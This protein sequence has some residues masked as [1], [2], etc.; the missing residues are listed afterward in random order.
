MVSKQ[1][2]GLTGGRERE[3]EA[4]GEGQGGRG[5]EGGRDEREGSVKPQNTRKI[6]SRDSLSHQST[7][8]Y[9]HTHAW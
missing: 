3:G 7:H 5:R 9:M 8:T 1:R 4:R 2:P 6:L